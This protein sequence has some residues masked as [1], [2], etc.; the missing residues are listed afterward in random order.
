MAPA[1]HLSNKVPEKMNIRRMTNPN[2]NPQTLT[3]NSP[4]ITYNSLL[5]SPYSQLTTR[6]SQLPSAFCFL[7]ANTNQKSW[8][9]QLEKRP[10][11]L[12]KSLNILGD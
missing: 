12:M 4:L 2:K 8:P 6:N 10:Y 5:F 3:S 11:S 7:Q 1:L 9:E